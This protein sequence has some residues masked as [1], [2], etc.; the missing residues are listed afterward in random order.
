MSQSTAI[1]RVRPRLRTE[2]TNRQRLYDTTIAGAPLRFMVTMLHLV[3]GDR[4]K[5]LGCWGATQFENHTDL[6]LM[7]VPRL[8]LINKN[9]VVAAVRWRLRYRRETEGD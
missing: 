7:G 8:A 9:P 6:T 2:R 1:T 4:S 3:C 5:I